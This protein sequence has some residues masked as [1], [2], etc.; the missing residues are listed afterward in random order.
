MAEKTSEPKK[1][2]RKKGSVN[3]ANPSTKRIPASLQNL[4]FEQ[5]QELQETITELM[6]SKKEEQIKILKEKLAEL[7][8]M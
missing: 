7:E 5:L 2:G 3:V 6:K 4:N 8:K 1:R